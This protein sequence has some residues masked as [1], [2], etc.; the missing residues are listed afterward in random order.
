[1]GL[2]CRFVLIGIQ[3]DASEGQKHMASFK[4][5]IAEI[6]GCPS[7]AEVA[8]KLEAFGLPESEEFGVLNQSATSSTVFA[9]IIRKSQTA[10]PRLDNETR[11]LTSSP[12]ER[13]TV[14]PFGIRPESNT[15]EI[16]SG[17][18]SSIEQVAAFLAGALALPVVVE[19]IEIDI[20]AA[21]EKL[22]KETQKFQFRS[23]RVSEYA[24]NSYMS[25]PYG[26]KFLDSE[27]GKDFLGEYSEFVVA[28][29]VKFAGPTGR[30]TVSLSPKACFGFSC[31]EDDQPQVQSILRKLI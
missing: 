1:M 16:Y 26:P 22:A 23:A 3:T 19:P 5:N 31:N 9:T 13:V 2:S 6:K 10:V 14:Y 24:H 21:L 29:S 27:H 20:A 30:V 7:A 12:V 17:S 8:K 11:E 25:G 28:A 15:L 4:L 18:A